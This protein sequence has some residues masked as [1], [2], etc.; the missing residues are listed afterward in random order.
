[1]KPRDMTQIALFAAIMGAMGLMPPITLG[2]TPVPITLQSM[3]VMLA[4]GILGAKKGALSLL[5]FLLITAAGLPLLSGG[6]GGLGVFVG[7]TA[8]FLCGYAIVPF[9]I[10][11]AIERMKTVAYWKIIAVNVLFGI[12]L[13]YVFGMFGQALVMNIS[14]L[15]ALKTN[16][17]FLPGDLLKVMLAS[18]LVCRIRKSPAIIRQLGLQPSKNA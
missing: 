11:Y 15:T 1:M 10:G 4:G 12:M 6:V 7:P 13:L 3:G 17:I 16:L 9:F 2:I 14:L 5:V 18:Y 8:G